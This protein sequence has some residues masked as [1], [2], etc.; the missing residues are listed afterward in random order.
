MVV[1]GGCISG[2]VSQAGSSQIFGAFGADLASKN[3]SDLVK[4]NELSLIN[5][6]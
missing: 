2:V 1:L 5:L 6:Q 4:D 3:S